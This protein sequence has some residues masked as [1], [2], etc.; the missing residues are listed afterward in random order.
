MGYTRE[1][2]AGDDNRVRSVKRVLVGVL[3][4][5]LLVA[6]A[7]LGYG[8]I[9]GSVAMTADGFH[10]MFDGTSNVVGLVGMSLASRPADDDHPY[11]HG[12]YETFASLVI[13]IMLALAAWRVG[14]SAVERLV[15]P[16]EPARVD[17]LSFAIMLG[18]L[19]VNIGVTTYERKAGKR[20]GSEI[21]IADASHTASD[22]L[23]SLGVIV[24]LAAVKLG[25]PQADPLIAL[26]VA[27][28]ILVAGWRVLR[29]A[30]ATLSDS[31]RIAPSAIR[32]V[33]MSVPGVLGCHHVRTRGPASEVYVDLHIQVDPGIPV[34]SG[35]ATA[36]RVEKTVCVRFDQVRDVI[37]HLEPLDEYQRRKT[38]AEAEAERGE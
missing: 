11:G 38:A 27:G 3:G 31:M 37:V 29:S 19:A 5:N 10:S 16:G 7:K 2:G 24:G 12:K 9:T 14:S 15:S 1:I 18:T 25:F 34:A 4:L 35:H 8:M 13:A 26:V 22:V 36:E 30:Q 28:F 32:D 23:V 17:A 20:L 21:L 6:F 33:V